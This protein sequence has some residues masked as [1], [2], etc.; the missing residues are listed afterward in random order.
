[1]HHIPLSAQ[2]AALAGVALGLGLE[3]LRLG[4]K[5]RFPLSPVAIGLGFVIP[6]NTCLS[7]FIGS[8][9]FWLFGLLWPQRESKANQVLVQTQKASWG[10]LIA[11][12]D[13]MGIGVAVAELVVPRTME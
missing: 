5:N 4:T 13:L 11:G 6:F 12:G 3:L 1:L 8:F 9:L 10:G 7:M 2:Y